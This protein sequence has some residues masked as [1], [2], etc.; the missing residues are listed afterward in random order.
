MHNNFNTYS[1]LP[2]LGRTIPGVRVVFERNLFSS[3]EF[4]LIAVHVA[5][6]DILI[7]NDILSICI[8]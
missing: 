6:H 8:S 3:H 5:T 4:D 2:K 7:S 1:T